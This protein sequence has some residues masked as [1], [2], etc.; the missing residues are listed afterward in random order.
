MAADEPGRTRDKDAGGS[1]GQL[2]IGHAGSHLSQRPAMR[3]A[4]PFLPASLRRRQGVSDGNGERRPPKRYS[5]ACRS[6]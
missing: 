3:R 5:A 1:A 2:R 4:R 6:S